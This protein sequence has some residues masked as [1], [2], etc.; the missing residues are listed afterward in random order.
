M[1]HISF[2]LKDMKI[3]KKISDFI[4]RYL[5]SIWKLLKKQAVSSIC[6]LK[7]IKIMVFKLMNFLNLKINFKKTWVIYSNF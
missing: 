4:W 2:K 1:Q 3:N 7:R 5:F 6:D